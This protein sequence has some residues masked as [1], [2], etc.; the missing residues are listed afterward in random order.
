M[1]QISVSMADRQALL[2]KK[3]SQTPLTAMITD[4]ASTRCA[5]PNISD[6]LH[7]TVTAGGVLIPIAVHTAVGGDSDGPV[8]GDILC[9]A[10]ASCLDSTIRIIANRLKLQLVSLEVSASAEIDVRGTLCLEPKVPVGFQKMHVSVT[11][12][13]PPGTNQK[14]ITALYHGAEHSCV[15]LQTLKKA[16]PVTTQYHPNI[17]SPEKQTRSDC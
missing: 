3:Y 12:H 17:G 7:S 2:A 5:N 4:F 6:P 13:A 9:A 11:L 10:L 14:L 16:L 8:P 1:N 15:V